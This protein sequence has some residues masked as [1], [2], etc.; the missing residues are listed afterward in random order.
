MPQLLIATVKLSNFPNVF[1]PV[2]YFPVGIAGRL[3][4]IERIA[5]EWL[6]A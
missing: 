4:M 3:C 2:S 6:W 1:P 5:N